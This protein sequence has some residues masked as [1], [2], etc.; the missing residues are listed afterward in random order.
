MSEVDEREV[1]TDTRSMHR[2]ADSSPGRVFLVGAVVIVLIVAGLLAAI[3]TF[4]FPI[5]EANS[6][7]VRQVATA[8]AQLS[9]AMTQE[10]LTPARAI[11]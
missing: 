3:R 5:W 6:E 8:Q 7:G 10:A 11:G 9:V 1:V 4:V 2:A